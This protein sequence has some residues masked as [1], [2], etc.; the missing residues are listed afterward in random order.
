MLRHPSRPCPPKVPR[1]RLSHPLD[2]RYQKMGKS[3]CRTVNIY[4]TIIKER[5]RKF[6][7]TDVGKT[8]TDDLGVNRGVL[9]HA[10]IKPNGFILLEIG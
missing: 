3:R 6:I 9:I 4:R 10:C 8:D 5:R 2:H 7:D 1:H